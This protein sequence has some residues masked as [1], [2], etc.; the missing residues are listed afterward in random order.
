MKESRKGNPKPSVPLT[1]TANTM[2]PALFLGIAERAAYVP[3]GATNL[4]KW[5]V[6]G[7][8]S[9]IL[10]YIFPLPLPPWH[11]AVALSQGVLTEAMRFALVD[12]SGKELGFFDMTTTP[13]PISPPGTPATLRGKPFLFSQHGWTL[14]FLPLGNPGI[15]IERPGNVQVRVGSKSGES[16]GQL[17]FVLIDP[18]ALEP[19]RIAAIRSDPAATKAVRVEF[20]CRCCDAKARA[21]AALERDPKIESEGWVWYAEVSDVFNCTCG[22]TNLSLETVRRNLHGLLGSPRPSSESLQF[23]PLYEQAALS[24]LRG[25]YLSLLNGK[26]REE[27]MQVF[28]QNNPVLLH[29]FPAI[30]LFTKPPILTEYFADFAIVTPQKELILVEIEKTTTRLIKKDGGVAADLGHAFDQ[31]RSWLHV[32]DEHRLAVLD[33]LKIDRNEVS[34]VRGVVI[35][36]RDQGYDALHLRR[37]K[38]QDWGRISLLTYD[39]LLFALDSL[40]ARMGKL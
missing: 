20:G 2:L 9:I 37:L 16:I 3:D 23:V 24:T 17:I 27:V 8:R 33:S 19:E 21:Y 14:L 30:R 40:I 4:S 1:T 29:I 13:E 39:D 31:V 6:L 12:E 36:G 5:N 7:L 25:E 32:V 22:R 15:I 34:A 28:L 11:I 26:H 18:P 38:G 10:S 35:A